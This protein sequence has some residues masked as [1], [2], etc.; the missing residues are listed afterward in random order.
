MKNYFKYL[1]LIALAVVLVLPVAAKAATTAEVQVQI[2][3]IMEQ[4][5]QL[6][7]QV[8]QLQAQQGT[9]TAWCHDF[10]TNLRVGDQSIEVRN[11]LIALTR[12]GFAGQENND[13]TSFNEEAASVVTAF[14]QKYAS[15][16]LAPYGLKYGTGFVGKSTRAKL[17]KLYGCLTPPTPPSIPIVTPIQQPTLTAMKS[18]SFNGQTSVVGADMRIGSFKLAAGLTED[19]TVNTINLLLS[20][21]ASIQNLKLMDMA[22]GVQIGVTKV[23]PS[24]NNSFSVNMVISS[25]SVKT[26][27]VIADI[28]ANANSATPIQATVSATGVGNTTGISVSTISVPLQV[29]TVVGNAI[30]STTSKPIISFL[31]TS[32]GTAGDK[33]TVYG[34]NFHSGYTIDLKNNLDVLY[35]P[36]TTTFISP[37]SLSFVVPYI[38]TGTYTINVAT[39]DSNS[40]EVSFKIVSSV[41]TPAPTVTTTCTD[42]DG[43]KSYYVKGI[44]K[45]CYSDGSC[46]LERA[47][48]CIDSNQ[49]RE[50]YCENNVVKSEFFSCPNGCQ[51]GA[52]LS[53]TVTPAPTLQA[54]ELSASGLKISYSKM[55]ASGAYRKFYD[56]KIVYNGQTFNYYIHY[57]DSGAFCK[58]YGTSV[59]GPSSSMSTSATSG[60]NIEGDSGK[61]YLRNGA[62][63]PQS[64]VQCGDI[65]VPSSSILG[66]LTPSSQ[67]SASI[68]ENIKVS[69]DQIQKAINNW[70]K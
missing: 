24:S 3:A 22:S 9:A 36:A 28:P 25:A 60:W 7:Q 62:Y 53:A 21:A 13:W 64:T 70:R 35:I 58:L 31:S 38:S 65:G 8:T 1:L 5:K 57:S 39:A 19:I 44:S 37:T 15:E 23:V 47:E 2:N 6:Q 46:T 40:N 55:D 48:A 41:T 51:N 54:Q 52:C 69:L 61:F 43:G 50:D 34:S 14:Q 68:L 18:E 30:P 29:I 20:N 45:Q 63:T 11:L 56:P 32:S 12:E 17:N 42:S 33:I 4:I 66:G 49:L 10:N 27:D 26:I 59:Y 16:I 67:Y